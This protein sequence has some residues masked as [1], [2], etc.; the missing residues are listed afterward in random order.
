MISKS[1]IS[2]R[3]SCS[4]LVAWFPGRKG[5]IIDKYQPDEARNLK[6]YGELPKDF[7]IND[8]GGDDCSEPDEFVDF[9]DPVN[10]TTIWNSI[11]SAFVTFDLHRFGMFQ[12][13]SCRWQKQ[14]Q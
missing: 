3:W 11:A 1:M 6:I 8:F 4:G 9:G 5:D 12:A 10:V 13:Q 7:K 14:F 2:P